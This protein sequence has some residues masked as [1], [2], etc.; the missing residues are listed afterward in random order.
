MSRYILFLVLIFTFQEGDLSVSY[1]SE[2]QTWMHVGT[3]R[4]YDILWCPGIPRPMKS[5]T[6]EVGS[7]HQLF[8]KSPLSSIMH[9][10][11][12]TM[13]LGLFSFSSAC[14]PAVILPPCHIFILFSP[15]LHST[16]QYLI[17]FP[18]GANI[19][20][21]LLSSLTFIFAYFCVLSNVWKRLYSFIMYFASNPASKLSTSLLYVSKVICEPNFLPPI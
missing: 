8:L 6:L 1:I 16:F 4:E 14:A 7:R 13:S 12:R 19:P 17:G 10:N 18:N 9:S 20:L 21:Y 2:S 15:H 5:E 3:S 11:V